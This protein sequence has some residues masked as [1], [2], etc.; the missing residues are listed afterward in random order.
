MDVCCKPRFFGH[1]ALRLETLQ[2]EATLPHVWIWSNP[3]FKC[4]GRRSSSFACAFNAQAIE[5]STGMLIGVMA[6]QWL[7]LRRWSFYECRSSIKSAHEW[8][9]LASIAWGGLEAF[10]SLRSQNLGQHSSSPRYKSLGCKQ[11]ASILRGSSA[12]AVLFLA[13]I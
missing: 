11:L 7:A 9:S 12:W 13:S 4:W 6:Y 3:S 2:D 5:A 8:L 1:G 10:G